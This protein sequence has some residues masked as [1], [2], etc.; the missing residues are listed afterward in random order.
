MKSFGK[1]A[2]IT[3]NGVDYR[4]F[5]LDMTAEDV[6]DFIKDFDPNEL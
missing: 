3:E 2:I 5:K 4:F 1:F 6:I